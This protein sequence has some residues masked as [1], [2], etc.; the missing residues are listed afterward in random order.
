MELAEAPSSEVSK[1]NET[2]TRIELAI[3]ILDKELKQNKIFYFL[4]GS[5][6]RLSYL[7]KRP[8]RLSDIDIIIPDPTQR[9]RAEEII[10]TFTQNSPDL[11]VDTSL[12][13]F[14]QFKDGK[15]ELR[16]GDLTLEVESRLMEER[17]VRFGNVE[18]STLPPQTLLHTYSLVG[19]PFREKDW[20]N[21]FEFARYIKGKEEFE[22]RLFDKFHQ[23]NKIRWQRSPLRRF[24]HLWRQFV[25]GLPPTAKKVLLDKIYPSQPAKNIRAKINDLDRLICTKAGSPE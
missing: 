17:R 25:T 8:T 16:Y 19:Q 13:E 22:H 11:E 24:Q 20:G 18:F 12:S 14:I 2:Q 5:Y 21:I 1:P 7:G 3:G 6:A 4:V 23:F 9:T 10:D 15:W